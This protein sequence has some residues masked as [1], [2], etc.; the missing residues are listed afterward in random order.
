MPFKSA[1]YKLFCSKIGVK[2]M[3]GDEKCDIIG[4]GE[5][6]AVSP[7]ILTRRL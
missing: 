3:V 1:F 7:G 5:F 2:M 4:L 6:N